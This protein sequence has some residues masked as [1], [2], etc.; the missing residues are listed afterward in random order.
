M[1]KINDLCKTYGRQTLLENISFNI[2]PGEKIGLVGRNGHGKTTLFRLILGWEEPDSGEITIP[3]RYTVGYLKQHINFTTKTVLEEGCLGLS[4]ERADESW[5]VEKVLAGLGFSPADMKRHPDEFSGGFQVRLNLAK[6]LV[7]EPDLLLLDEPTNYL[8]I[9]S[10]SWLTRFLR[11]WKGE[12]MLI[13][14]DRGF[15][16]GIIT[17]TVGIHRRKIRKVAGSTEKLYQQLL[18]EEEIYEKTRLN[19]E[20]KRRETE[21][22]INRFRAKARL[23]SMVQSRVKALARQVEMSKLETLEDLDFRFRSASFPSKTM[24]EIRNISFAYEEDSPR[25]INNFSLIVG[26]ADRIAVIGKNGKGKSTLLRLLAGELTPL[27]G[28]I[29]QHSL[30]KIGYFGQTNVNRLDPDKTVLEEI[31]ASHPDCTPQQARNISGNLMFESDMALKKIS[32]LSGGERSRVSLGK[33]LVAPAHM[34]LLDEPTNHL[35]MESSEALMEAI[36]AFAGT[37][38]FVTHNET[39][40]HNLANRL[41]VFDRG[42]IRLFEGCYQDFLDEV[43][44]EEGRLYS[45]LNEQRPVSE[46][47]SYNLRKALKKEKA[48][49]IQRRSETLRPM[50]MDIACLEKSITGLEEEMSRNNSA[51]VHASMVG[52]APTIAALSKRNSHIEPELKA[53]Y[54]RLCSLQESYESKLGNFERE[55]A[56]LAD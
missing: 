24:M 32:V 4:P 45:E 28:T 26:K 11:Q 41:I 33:L 29:R 52:D 23:S 54:D 44:W 20:K 35:D 12:L 50:E 40:L 42:C 38:I 2:N 19:N 27:Q 6:A 31:T 21:A 22:F 8:D 47:D 43:G 25:L 34:L 37:V 46:A 53:L 17:H 7:S 49:I 36:K 9:T 3:S 13:T 39:Y 56:M 1:L 5:K 48:E 51:L 15:M 18:K 55:L 16:D 14:H 10:I 30:L